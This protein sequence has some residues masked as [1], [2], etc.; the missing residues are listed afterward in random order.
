MKNYRLSSLEERKKFYEKEFDLEKMKRWFKNNGLRFPQICAIDA[1]SDS[2]IIIDKKLKNTMLYF[3]FSEIKEKIKKYVP[4]DVYYDRNI[5]ENPDKTLKSLNFDK[6]DKQELVFDVDAD[7]IQCNHNKKE[8]ICLK[9]LRKTFLSSS[10]IKKVLKRKF[11]FNKIQIFYSGAGFHVHVLDK[12][13]FIL[14]KRER[15]EITKALGKF[16]IDEWVSEGSIYLIKMPFT[17]NSLVSRKVV[18][19]TNNNF[20]SIKKTSIPKFLKD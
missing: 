1:G 2:K 17:L 18:P 12:K 7:N 14:S 5:Y 13:A 11:N 9:C 16:P 6:W 10:E 20:N 15:K 4:E 19:L 8:R 3:K